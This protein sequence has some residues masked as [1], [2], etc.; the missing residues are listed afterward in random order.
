MDQRCLQP[1][2]I[3]H[4]A[5]KC[6]QRNHQHRRHEDGGHLVHQSLYGRLGSLRVLYQADDAREHRFRAHGGHLHDNAAVAID[7]TS[8]ERRPRLAHHRQRFTRQHGFINL[9]VPFQQHAIHRNALARPHHQLVACH[10][11]GNRHIHLAISADQMRQ[12]GPQRVQRADGSR[13]LP[14]GPRLQPFAQQHQRDHHGRGL[15]IQMRHMPRMRRGP[16]P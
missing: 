12:F 6:D 14:L 13:R 11:L 7:R 2:A 5:Q 4:P 3:G 1:R 9:G 16:Q 10:H 15:E 8:R